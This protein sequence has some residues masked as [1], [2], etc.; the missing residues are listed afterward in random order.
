[1]KKN[2]Y[3]AETGSLFTETVKL[4]KVYEVITVSIGYEVSGIAKN[5]RNVCYY[6]DFFNTD[7]LNITTTFDEL[8]PVSYKGE[9]IKIKW[10]LTIEKIQ[11]NKD[12]SKTVTD[13]MDFLMYP[14]N[15]AKY[16]EKK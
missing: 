8:V 12:D 3:V 1:M 10:F 5:E 7:V 11:K 16:L 6:E 15:Y 2:I 9:L 13:R 4:N 14:K